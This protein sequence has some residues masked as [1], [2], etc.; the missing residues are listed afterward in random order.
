MHD[1]LDLRNLSNINSTKTRGVANAVAAGSENDLDVLCELITTIPRAE[2]ALFLPALFVNVDSARIPDPNTLDFLLSASSHIPSIYLGFKSI[3]AISHLA[4]MYLVPVAVSQD[5]WPRIWN[6]IDFLHSCWDSI[7]MMVQFCQEKVIL[8][9]SILIL[10]LDK[11]HETSKTM[12]S[13]PGVRRLA[14]AA[15][16][17]MVGGDPGPRDHATLSR[18]GGILSIVS[19]SSQVES[20]FDEVVDG[21]GGNITDLASTMVRHLSRAHINPNPASIYALVRGCLSFLRIN[22]ESRC[23]LKVALKSEG[24]TSTLIT[25]IFKLH[26]IPAVGAMELCLLELTRALD[27]PSDIALAIEAGL[28]QLVITIAASMTATDKDANLRQ[29]YLL[30][31]QMLETQLRLPLLRYEVLSKLASSFEEILEFAERSTIH[32][33]AFQGQWQDLHSSIRKP[34]TLFMSWAAQGKPSFTGCDNIACGKIGL[35]HNFKCCSNCQS[36][37]YCSEDCQSADWR[38]EHRGMCQRL[39]SARL[40]PLRP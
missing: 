6:W 38:A 4:A 31:E 11:D 25:A 23:R 19:D 12:R 40:G 10:A 32:T 13:T 21:V 30:I 24:F 26:G 15:W 36:A 5:L 9:H 2:A 28:L 35:K 16:K 27:S 14:A 34:L 8:V 37:T 20:N 18:I 22:S 3:H 29:I 1:S 7:P 39:R 17:S 33:S